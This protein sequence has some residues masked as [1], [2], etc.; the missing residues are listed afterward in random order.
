MAHIAPPPLISVQFCQNLAIHQQL[1]RIGR[2][3]LITPFPMTP[4]F[5]PA[6]IA[7][8]EDDLGLCADLVEFLQL[9]G[10][11]ARGFSSAED[12][13]WVWPALRFDLLLL[14]ITLPGASGLEVARRVRAQ[15]DKLGIVMLTGLDTT[16]DQVTGLWAGADAY[17]SK[18]SPLE[19]IEATCHSL[20]RR[21]D[22]VRSPAPDEQ[23]APCWHLHERQW[24][25]EAPSGARITLTH[26]ER[27]MLT[28][29]FNSPGEAVGRD[30]LLALL[31]KQDSLSNLR[32]LDNAASRLRRK[33]QQACGIELP[34]RPS[35]GRG[36][37]FT[38]ECEMNP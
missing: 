34:V 22:L 26:T 8:V 4:S 12:F 28:A 13:F 23:R 9:R 14:D 30:R 32:N 16:S 17:L 1:D 18:K 2:N 25:L 24:L 31:D 33:V 7:V 15:G 35:Y 27:V 29:L 3:P 37:I 20:L 6:L 36:Y 19:V 21:L 10:M 11:S 5:S 38:G